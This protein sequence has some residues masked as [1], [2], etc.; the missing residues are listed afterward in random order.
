MTAES[1]VHL[2]G[3]AFAH[4]S[5]DHLIGPL[6][7]VQPHPDNPRNGD[8]EAIIESIR[9]NGLYAGLVAQRSTGRIV[10]GN[11]RYA[12]LL[13]LGADRAPITWVD[14]DD[15][16]ALRILLAD[17][18]VGDRAINDEAQLLDLIRSLDSLDGSGFTQ[19]DIERLITRV[20]APLELLDGLADGDRLYDD[21]AA[22][23]KVTAESGDLFHLPYGF[24]VEQRER[25]L[26]AIKIARRLNPDLDGAEAIVLMAEDYLISAQQSAQED[27]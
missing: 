3:D 22:L 16:L 26:T 20:E 2:G 19:R 24:T 10:V 17:N 13:E 6:T 4:A 9:L 8:I 23:A 5:L 12:A 1:R 18:K 25:L 11:H 14:V 21:E 7:D 27:T 15:T